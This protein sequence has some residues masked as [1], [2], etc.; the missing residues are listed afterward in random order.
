MLKGLGLPDDLARSALPGGL[1]RAD[2]GWL[3]A[4]AAPGASL[5]RRLRR[6]NGALPVPI[7]KNVARFN[8]RVTNRITGTFADRLPGFAILHHVGRTSGR[9]V[10]DSDQCLSR[11]QRLYLRADLRRRHRLGEERAGGGRLRDRD[12]WAAHP[13]HQPAHHHRHGAPLG[14]ATGTPAVASGAR[15][16]PGDAGDAPD[17]GSIA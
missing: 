11:W 7:S 8:R 9:D 12:P 3:G 17:A 13:A 10:L 14:V 4:L 5:A 6:M 16:H 1:R 2:G 15:L